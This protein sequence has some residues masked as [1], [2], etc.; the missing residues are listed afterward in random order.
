MTSQ[1]LEAAYDQAR[2]APNMQSVLAR[3]G[4]LSEAAREVIGVPAR[5]EYGPAGDERL[6]LYRAEAERAPVVVFVHGG[7]WRGGHAKDHGFPAE[8]L[9]AAGA[10]FIALDFSTAVEANGDLSVLVDQVRRALVWVSRNCFDFDGD[11]DRI[12]V[13]GHSSGAHLAGMA[14]ST[15]WTEFGLHTNPVKAGLLISGIYDLGPLRHT[16]RST[17]IQLDDQ[18]ERELSPL[19][20]VE[21]IEAPLILAVGSEESPEFQRQMRA[22]AEAVSKAGKQIETCVIQ[23]YNHFEVFDTVGNP[24]SVLGRHILKLIGR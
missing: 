7:G 18:V 19:R 17:Y 24:Y 23:T 4:L 5:I 11:A 10:H 1:D 21:L 22:Y 15:K 13:V 16:S 6:D 12:F 2:W 9:L 8:M 3:H 20:N 14:L